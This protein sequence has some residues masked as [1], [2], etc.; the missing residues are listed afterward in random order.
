MRLRVLSDL[1]VEAIDRHR[2]AV[3]RFRAKPQVS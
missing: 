1:A 3:G 2:A